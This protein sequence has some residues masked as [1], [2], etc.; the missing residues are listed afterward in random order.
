M[1][2]YSKHL[3][4]I[5]GKTKIFT[6]VK[7]EIP[8]H[9]NYLDKYHVTREGNV[10]NSKTCEIKFNWLVKHPKI[11]NHRGYARIEFKIKGKRV[12]WFVHRLVY[13]CF[14][15]KIPSGKEINHID[16][17]TMNNSIFNLELVTKKQN[18]KHREKLKKEK[19]YAKLLRQSGND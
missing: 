2:E 12:R 15:G 11:K 7:V 16:G 17:N 8:E 13:T 6:S 3:T 10:V 9:V 19:L 5:K 18:I 1:Q 14:I 4:I